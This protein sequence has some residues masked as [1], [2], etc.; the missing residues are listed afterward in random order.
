LDFANT[1]GGR[2][3]SRTEHLGRYEDLV[4]WARQARIVDD[5]SARMLERL[6]RTHKTQAESVLRQGRLVRESI[7]AIFLAIARGRRPRASDIEDLNVFLREAQSHRRVSP[8]GG[9][10]AWTWD[11]GTKNLDRPLWPVASDAADLLTS[12]TIGPVREC[13]APG[14]GWLFVD[15]TKNHSRRWCDM[16]SCGNR[17][18]ARRHYARSAGAKS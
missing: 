10:F 2:F 7:F 14:C 8:S 13:A 4:E 15:S 18:K 16:A 17:E 9:G 6:A 11:S 12:T 1:V 5:R 3:R